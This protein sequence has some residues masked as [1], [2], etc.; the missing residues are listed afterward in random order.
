M[1]EEMHSKHFRLDCKNLKIQDSVLEHTC[2]KYFS[3]SETWRL[4]CT[5]FR[6]VC[7]HSLIV[8]L[9]V[10]SSLYLVFSGLWLHQLHFIRYNPCLDSNFMLTTKPV[11]REPSAQIRTSN[12]AKDTFTKL[13]LSEFAFLVLKG[14][15]FHKRQ[16]D[17]VT[18]H[19]VQQHLA[20]FIT[21][22]PRI[23]NK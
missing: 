9:V 10:V 2:C 13:L 7:L 1:Y 3:F 11:K 4:R 20:Y 6:K 14:L 19:L 17:Y 5:K 21:K 8:K 15:K 12:M 18:Q 23:Y 22:A 16:Q